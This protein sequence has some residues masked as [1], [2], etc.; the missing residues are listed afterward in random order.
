MPQTT[1]SPEKQHLSALA[2][3]ES[4]FKVDKKIM[5]QSINSHVTSKVYAYGG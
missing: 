1:T 4:L 2:Y 3:T 5:Y